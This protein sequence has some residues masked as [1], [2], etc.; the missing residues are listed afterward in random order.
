M[1]IQKF[2]TVLTKRKTFCKEFKLKLI[3]WYFK[4]GKNIN[5]TVSNFLIDRN[6]VRKWL[7]DEE[8]IR[9]LKHSRK[10]RWHGKVKFPFMEKEFHSEFPDMQKEGKHF[11]RWCFNLQG[12]ELVKEKISEETS[13]FKLSHRWFKGFF[14]RHKIS[15]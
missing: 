14:R 3:N 1:C 11:K 7:N 2:K 12:R 4:N 15:L 13:T 5:H 6:Q 9:S 10:S 8:K